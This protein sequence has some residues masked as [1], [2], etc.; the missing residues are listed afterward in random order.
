MGAH[1]PQGM[2]VGRRSLVRLRLRADPL[3]VVVLAFL[4]APVGLVGMEIT[5]RA[6]LADVPAG[7]DKVLG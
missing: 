5:A 7:T 1:R 2:R 4:T 6:G 3:V